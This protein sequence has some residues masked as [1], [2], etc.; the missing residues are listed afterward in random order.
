MGSGS[1]SDGASTVDPANGRYVDDKNEPLSGDRLR[2]AVKSTQSTDAFL[3]VAKRMPMRMRV[4]MNVLKLPLFLCEFSQAKLP[5]EVRQ[6]RINTPAGASGGVGMPGGSGSGSSG[7]TAPSLSRGSS[8]T[9]A[10]MGMSPESGG[11]GSS[12]GMGSGGGGMMPGMGGMMPGAGLGGMPGLGGSGSGGGTGGVA[13]LNS[14]S[15][16]DTTVDIY[17]IIYIYNP[18]DPAKLGLDTKDAVASAAA[19]GTDAAVPAATDAD[20]AAA[21]STATTDDSAEAG[22]SGEVAD[23]A[24][25]AAAPADDGSAPA[26]SGT[27]TAPADSAAPADGTTPPAA[28]AAPM[29]ADGRG[30]THPLRRRPIRRHQAAVRK[31]TFELT[32]DGPGVLIHEEAETEPR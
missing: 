22:T 29:A 25:D 24:T 17:G 9:G 4:R 18:V 14:E 7:F 16:Y 13:T 8:G 11:G 19:A 26:D 5:V 10:S 30:D 28:P 23:P 3:S 20:S 27:P 1:G 15:P 6:V 12:G 21:D 2:S 31:T 32:R